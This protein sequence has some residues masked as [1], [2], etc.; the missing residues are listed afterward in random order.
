[1]RRDVQQRLLPYCIGWI[2]EDG[3]AALY[4][5]GRALFPD[6]LRGL[7][8]ETQPKVWEA[9]EKARG[10]AA[11]DVMGDQLRKQLDDRGTLHVIRQ[12]TGAKPLQVQ[13]GVQIMVAE[14]AL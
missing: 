2:Y 9:L 14:E 1:M 8:M 13:T 11:L 10:A 3:A 5:R 12:V 4:D 7:L 6:D